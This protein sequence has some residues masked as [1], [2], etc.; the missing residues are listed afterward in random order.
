M[1]ALGLWSWRSHS[2]PRLEDSG[3]LMGGHLSA[4]LHYGCRQRMA[5]VEDVHKGVA[6]RCGAVQLKPTAKLAL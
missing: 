3:K 2:K 6:V 4:L 5:Y 1:N